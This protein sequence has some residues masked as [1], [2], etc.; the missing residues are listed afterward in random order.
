[1]NNQKSKSSNHRFKQMASFISIF[2]KVCIAH[3][4]VLRASRPRIAGRM[5]ATRGI[6]HLLLMMV[7]I[8]H[9]TVLLAHAEIIPYEGPPQAAE[10][11]DKVLVPYG[12]F[13]ELWNQAHPE[14]MVDLPQGDKPISFADVRYKVTVEKDRLNLAL[15][16]RIK[17]YGE[18]WTVLSIPFTTLAVVNA[19]LDGEPARLQAGPKGMVLMIP[20]TTNGRL[21]LQA[22][23]KPETLG[24]RGSA[25][26]SVPPLPGAVMTVVLSEKDLEL[27]IDRI[28]A[29]PAKRITDES[30][31]YTFGLGMTR[32]LSLRWLP[33]VGGGATDRTLSANSQHDVYVFHW[34][35]VGVS[36]ITYSFSSGEYD[37]FALLVPKDTMLTEVRG[38]NIRDFRDVGK[39]TV[40]GKVFKLIEIRLHR[41]A[42]KQHELTIRW[43]SSHFLSTEGTITIAADQAN[44]GTSAELSLPRAG[45]VS[46]ESGTVTL[47]S[48]GGM[49]VKVARVTG[50][51]RMNM[52]V[53]KE[54]KGAELAADSAEVVARYY[55]PYRPFSLSVQLSRLAVSPQVR[56]NQLVRINTDRVEL[57]VQANLKVE[58]GRLFGAAFTLPEDY[59]LLSAVGPAVS[60][61]YERSNEKGKFLHIEFHRGQRETEIAL[62]LVRRDVNLASLAVP[63]VSY[64]DEEGRLLSDTKGRLAVQVAASLEAETITERNLKSIAP[65]TLSNW[66]DNRQIGS[67]Q[68]AYRYEVADPSL[69]LAVRRLPTTIRAEVFAGLAIR[70]TAAVY[71][72][73]VRYNIIGSPVDHLSFRLPS[74]YAPMIAVESQAMRSVTQ[75]DAGSGQT[76]WTVSLVNEV[77]G[78]VDVAVNFALP[79]DPS[80]TVLKMAPLQ[81]ETPAGHRSIVAV[82]NLS[83][84]E[85]NVTDS[86]N[87]SD[88]PVS[89]QQKLMPNE[90]R[91]SLQ[92]VF[93]S[94]EVDWSLNLDFKPA[95]MATRIQ[96]VV[97]LLEV[98]TVIQRNGRCRYEAKV[99]LQNRS[100]QFLR[101]R[102]PEGLRLWSANVASEPVK[103]VVSADLPKTDVLIPLV[104]TSPGGLPYDIFLYFADD[105]IDPLVAPLNGMTHLE[106]PSISIVGIPVMQTTWSLR[107]PSGYR[108]FRPGGN[109]SPAAGTVEML[110]FGIEAK[111]EQLKRLERTYRDVAGS[112][113]RKKQV[114]KYNWRAFNE[115]LADE[116][117]QAESY[118]AARR[119]EVSDKEYSRLRRKLGEQ[120]QRQDMLLGKNVLF[121]QQQQEQAGRDL[122]RYLNVNA[123]N[124][125][126]AEVTRN[127]I[128][129]EKP[130]FLSKSEEQQIARLEKELEVSQKQLELFEGKEEAPD[131]TDAPKEDT[132]V[133]AGT[134]AGE[135]VGGFA[136]KDAEM[137]E[138]LGQLA[139][140]SA[141][142][143][144]QKQTQLRE[145]LEELRDNRAQRYFQ[146]DSQ[147]VPTPQSQVEM[148]IRQPTAEAE[149]S[150]ELHS[151]A[152]APSGRRRSSRTQSFRGQRMLAGTELRMM[153]EARA[154]GGPV[155]PP[156]PSRPSVSMGE[157]FYTAKGTYSLPVSLPEGEV[158]LDF[159]RPAGEAELSL[160]AIS[161]DT[162]RNVYG[163]IAIVAVLLVI[164]GLTKV[165]PRPQTRRPISAKLIVVYCVLSVVLAFMLGLAGLLISLAVILFSEAKRGAFVRPAT[166]EIEAS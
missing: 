29:A 152:Y 160:W 124:I 57:L 84:H 73:R 37:R 106:P 66:L 35:V 118:L 19:T 123:D 58:E 12:R 159:S 134:K 32:E 1:M 150:D 80:T 27:E 143:I 28:E 146:A 13:V 11:A 131:V 162:M 76:R 114:A 14:D 86:M 144:D 87:L 20:G 109:M 75:S 62:V 156:S 130:D 164:A 78:V 112:T 158:R 49:R 30:V 149:P 126:V 21:E 83:R 111:L 133:I 9:P 92:Y 70:A 166:A 94:F 52:E 23:M 8:A 119:H 60:N 72:Y 47:H 122:N 53:D 15:T 71:T 54:P 89:E 36:K 67:V 2:G 121:D 142:Q 59:E 105:G 91:E 10:Q 69:Q 5:P 113:S 145:Q 39:K 41:A 48:A 82:Q 38:T 40:E 44:P 18:D 110:S 165:W 7:C 97:D 99:A 116:I 63:M 88:L 117:G 98:T 51:R 120:R 46:R 129:Q 61:F 154:A 147:K 50:G 26:F 43:V 22:V 95:K 103:P 151:D 56:L 45:D 64:L 96:A 85:I 55:W 138:A 42:Q 101:V 77:T 17:T 93:E 128:L 34:A 125:G 100:E 107:L 127:Q 24:R 3:L 65:Q 25:R 132:L 104:K 136:D 135:I 108:Y 137:T 155:G 140:K 31:E 79:V 141:I 4:L 74:E 6:V 68:F 33:K 148:Q 157:S 139:R 115:K 163:T 161:Q 90:M 16:A 81:T 153:E 102:I